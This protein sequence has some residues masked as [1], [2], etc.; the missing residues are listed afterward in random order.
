MHWRLLLQA[1]A[2]ENQSYTLGVNRVGKDGLDI[3]Y[4]GDSAVIDP[5][6]NIIKQDADKEFIHTEKLSRE[7]LQ[8]YRTKFPVWMDSDTFKVD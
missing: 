4:R 6:G 7:K 5:L 3:N 8:K 1:R 2:I